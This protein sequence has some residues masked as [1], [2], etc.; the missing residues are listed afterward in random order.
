MRSYR[1]IVLLAAFAAWPALAAPDDPYAPLKLY[2]GQWR[3]T[4]KGGAAARVDN[5]CARTGVF[6]ACEQIVDGKPADLVVFIPKGHTAKGQ[7][8]RTQALDA[9]G[10]TAHPWSDLTIDG[11]NWVYSNE[12]ADEGQPLHRRTL[13]RFTGPDHIHFDVQSSTDGLTWT[14]QASGDEQTVR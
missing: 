11:D 13:N 2:A 10:A 6:F 7:A 14:T 12:K 4:P 1:L 8:Y 9:D 5:H 3:V